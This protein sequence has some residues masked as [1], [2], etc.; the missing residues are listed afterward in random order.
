MVLGSDRALAPRAD[1][2][3]E[4][5]PFEAFEMVSELFSR[6]SGPAIAQDLLAGAKQSLVLVAESCL[7]ASNHDRFRTLLQELWQ[8]SVRVTLVPLLPAVWAM[9]RAGISPDYYPGH[10]PVS[11]RSQ[12][13]MEQAADRKLPSEPGRHAA[14]IL[15][16]ARNGEVRGLLILAGHNPASEPPSQKLMEASGSVDFLALL[17]THKSPL[18]QCAHVVMPSLMSF[19]TQGTLV[20][21]GG[22]R[23]EA[24][25]AISSPQGL[26]PTWQ[27]LAEAT[28]RLG[29]P[30]GSRNLVGVQSEMIVVDQVFSNGLP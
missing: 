12:R 28:Q 4:I 26:R 20:S 27:V 25:P 16:G 24:I 11:P 8:E 10:R 30:T 23:Y 3:Q 9:R 21:G 17:A 13:I 19:E 5:E 18:T 22:E 2:H 29:G 1:L 6:G 15:E 14:E 7:T